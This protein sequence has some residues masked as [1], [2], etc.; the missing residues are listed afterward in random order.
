[1]IS[2]Q[3]NTDSINAQNNL[4]INQEFQ[5]KTIQS[6]TSGYRIN[7][8]GDDAAGLAVA[9]Q[10]RDN[11]TELTQGVQNASDAT[12]QLQIVDGGLSN[13]STI[14]DRMKTLATESASGTFTGNRSTLNQEYQGLVSEIT[15]QATNVGLNSGGSFNKNLSVYIGGASSEANATVNVDLSGTN[16]AVDAT[17]LGLTGSN[18]LGGGVELTN[19]TV[20]LNNTSTVAAQSFT[21]NYMANGTA[22]SQTFSISAG[23]TSNAMTQ[24][25][26]DLSSLG[27]NASIGSDGGL[28]FSGGT[29][30]T[31]KAGT[32]TGGLAT[33]GSTATNTSNYNFDGG[34]FT[35]P[36]GSNTEALT[37]ATSTGNTTYTVTAGESLSDTIAGLNTALQNSGSTVSAVMNSAG[38]GISFQGSGNFSLTDDASSGTAT[39]IQTA[40]VGGNYVVTAADN[41]STSNADSAINAINTAIANLGLVQG[42]V[43]AGENKLQYATNL[44][45]SQISNYSTAESNIRDADVAAEAAN[46]T[47][48]QVLQQSSIAAMAQ[49]NAEPQAILKLLQ[50]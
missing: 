18:V 11:I 10:L 19:N 27:I 46:L 21:F 35:A 40:Q 25:N 39:A 44:A 20:N 50:G 9:N 48:A 33:S 26:S 15:R 30:F 17:S 4:N 34:T 22:Q 12:A 13:I 36:T 47:K 31:V 7:S 43:G 41:G 23:S 8:S 3:T 2:I 42:S 29:D 6:L 38:N 1:M 49:A 45:N 37:I 5:S 28:Q 24:L 14:L 32:A 16:N